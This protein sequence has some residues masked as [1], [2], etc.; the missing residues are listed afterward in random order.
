MSYVRRPPPRSVTPEKSPHLCAPWTS[1]ARQALPTAGGT[2]PA[3]P[4]PR[5]L[6][7][8]GRQVARASKCAFSHLLGP[9]QHGW[10]SPCRLCE[11]GAQGGACIAWETGCPS[12]EVCVFGERFA[13]ECKHCEFELPLA[14]CAWTLEGERLIWRSGSGLDFVLA[15]TPDGTRNALPE[16]AGE[17]ACG[18]S[19]GW[20]VEASGAVDDH[21]YTKLVFRLCPA[22]CDEHQVDPSVRYEL[23][24]RGCPI[25]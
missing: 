14:D 6:H 1:R 17:A 15:V 7:A 18:E 11:A 19:A 5:A 9:D 4:V 25:S 16:V 2:P 13:C 12:T 24:R 3:C 21:A 23:G 20:Y 22:S 8:S 10:T